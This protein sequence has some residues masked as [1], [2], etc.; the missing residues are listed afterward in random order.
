MLCRC[1]RQRDA[2]LAGLAADGAAGGAAGGAADAVRL[3]VRLRQVQR[4]GEVGRGHSVL[5]RGMWEVGS[6]GIAC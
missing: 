5:R 1:R 4:G 6:W 2:Q 3:H